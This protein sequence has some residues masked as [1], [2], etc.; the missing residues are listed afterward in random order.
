MPAGIFRGKTF[1]PF[2]LFLFDQFLLVFFN[3]IENRFIDCR[4]FRTTAKDFPAG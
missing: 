1:K 4:C 3:F 2:L